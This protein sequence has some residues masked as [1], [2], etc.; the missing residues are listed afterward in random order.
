MQGKGKQFVAHGHKV[1]M[2]F[3]GG[4]GYCNA[5]ERSGAEMR[6]DLAFGLHCG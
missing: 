6:R 1:M 5:A 2:A 4:A 3:S